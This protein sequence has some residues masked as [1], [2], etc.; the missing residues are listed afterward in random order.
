MSDDREAR[1][2][3]HL[4]LPE[5]GR[6]GQAA[7]EESN[8]ACIGAGG[9]GSSALLYLAAAGIGTIRIIDDDDVEISNLQRQVIHGTKDMGRKKVDSAE[10]RLT[11]VN[12]LIK[13]EKFAERLDGKNALEFLH[14]IDLVIDGTDNIPARYLLN[15]ACEILGIPWIHAS[16][17]RYEGQL[18]VFNHQGSANYRDLFPN[19]PPAGSIPSCS[20]AGVLGA[21]PGIMGTMQAMEAIKIIAN[22]GQPLSEQ[23]MILDTRNMN[24]KILSYSKN[25]TRQLVTTLDRQ[26]E[27]IDSGCEVQGES[28]MQSM[29]VINLHERME[30]KAPFLLDVRRANEEVICSIPGTDLRVEHT[31]ILENLDSIPK[32][33]DIVVYCRSGIRSMSAIA[34]LATNG[35]KLEQLWNLDGG[36]LAW[37][38]EIDPSM[39][40]Y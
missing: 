25:K 29:T 2:A 23:L 26:D 8:V 27:Y 17:F 15:D 11:D 22:V 16:V 5:F 28:E 1:Y 6:K 7:L 9:L 31:Q 10:E 33:R 36:I 13:I 18:T 20:E 4:M 35:W 32:D 34:A 19:P 38:R 30:G 37:S 24:S 39:P 40:R 12:P 21:L 3:R 14:G